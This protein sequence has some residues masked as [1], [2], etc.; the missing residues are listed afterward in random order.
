MLSYPIPYPVPLTYE[1]AN[2]VARSLPH[3]LTSDLSLEDPQLYLCINFYIV[4]S[5]TQIN[6]PCRLVVC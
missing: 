6:Q 5:C 2:T 1:T 3:T 4:T